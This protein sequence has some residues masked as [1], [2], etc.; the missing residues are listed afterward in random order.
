M[1]NN[2]N[3]DEDNN[4]EENDNEEINENAPRKKFLFF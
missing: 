4:R 2:E 1:K 3:F